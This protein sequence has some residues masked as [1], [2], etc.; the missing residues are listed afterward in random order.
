MD[1]ASDRGHSRAPELADLVRVCRALNEH[2]AQHV[3][4]GGFAV[5]LHGF[6][7]ATKDVD[8]E[9]YDPLYFVAFEF[10]DKEPIS[11]TGAPPKEWRKP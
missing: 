10:A 11:M 2:E 1:D 3:L 4:I 8:L 6:V 7:R 5:A 9:I